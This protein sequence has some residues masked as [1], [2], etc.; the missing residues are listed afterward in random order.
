MDNDFYLPTV[1][2]TEMDQDYLSDSNSDASYDMADGAMSP[3]SSSNIKSNGKAKE[4]E[5]LENLSFE[6]AF[7][8]PAGEEQDDNGE[9]TS[10]L[11]SW[12]S[13][14]TGLQTAHGTEAS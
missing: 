5:K 10:I 11:S 6:G 7:T 13:K 1:T 2:V 14:I 9:Q 12:I 8:G 4:P 3:A